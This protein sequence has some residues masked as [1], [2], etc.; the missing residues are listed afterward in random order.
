MPLPKPQHRQH[1]HKRTINSDA[2]LRDD[3]MWDIEARMTDIK[4]ESVESNERDY[5]AAGEEF[6]DIRLRVTIDVSLKV[7]EIHASIDSAPFG[8]CP[9]IAAAYS[10]LVGL[11]IRPGWRAKVKELMGG[12]NGC[13][14]VND[15]L[16]VIATTAFQAMW[17]HSDDTT[18][19][20]GFALMLDTC[21]VWSK[22]GALAKQL[23]ADGCLDTED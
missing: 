18:K 12:T 10:K 15:L 21:H 3:G 9:N 2:Y 23:I 5:V 13:T 4:S 19:K 1:K 22:D 6:H 11:Q 14:H 20:Q 17:T 8:I 16:P 7:R